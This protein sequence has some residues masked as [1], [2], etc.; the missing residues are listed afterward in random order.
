MDQDDR[1]C[2]N[3]EPLTNCTTEQYL[4]TLLGECGCFPVNIGLLQKVILK[5]VMKCTY[6]TFKETLCTSPQDL[7]CVNKVK[8][9]TSSCL[10][11]C[12]GLIITTFANLQY[13]FDLNISDVINH[14]IRVDLIIYN[15]DINPNQS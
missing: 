8:V 2:Q 3:E 9:D 6:D 4:D 7:D 10:K 12:S 14:S 13:V 1:K 5:N 15:L 11:P